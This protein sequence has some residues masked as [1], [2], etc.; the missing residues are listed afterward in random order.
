MYR[1]GAKNVTLVPKAS[2]LI[3]KENWAVPR[4]EKCAI[5]SNQLSFPRYLERCC[6][7]EVKRGHMFE[8]LVWIGASEFEG[9]DLNLSTLIS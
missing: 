9:L 7:M 3:G 5:S 8:N 2:K 1:R 4:L 6:I